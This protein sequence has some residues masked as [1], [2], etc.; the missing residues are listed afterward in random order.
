MQSS[1][2]HYTNHIRNNQME[3]KTEVANLIIKPIRHL[4]I[5]NNTTEYK[6]LRFLK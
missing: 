2:E 3:L 6:R 1:C 4:G 5:F